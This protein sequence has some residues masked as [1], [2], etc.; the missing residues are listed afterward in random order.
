MTS[1]EASSSP[2]RGPHTLRSGQT[3]QVVVAVQ[4]V[5]HMSDRAANTGPRA[6]ISSPVE[7]SRVLCGRSSE[8][9]ESSFGQ[10]KFGG[11][12]CP[13]WGCRAIIRGFGHA[14]AGIF[15]PEPDYRA[16]GC[17]FSPDETLDTCAGTLQESGSGIEFAF[18][19]SSWP[20]SRML[21]LQPHTLLA[22]C[23]LG[24]ADGITILRRRMAVRP[25]GATR[26]KTLYC[27]IRRRKGKHGILTLVLTWP[28]ECSLLSGPKWR[29]GTAY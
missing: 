22:S 8:V 26:G 4:D 23:G 2:W 12:T 21:L 3:G 17:C 6:D 13:R 9:Q 11:L 18:L 27:V 29:G 1:A 25:T 7:T 19:V 5:T 24:C 20:K 14:L 28:I 15:P 10:A 16:H